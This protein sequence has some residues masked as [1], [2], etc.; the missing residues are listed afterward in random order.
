MTYCINCSTWYSPKGFI[1]IER[2]KYKTD[3]DSHC[4]ECFFAYTTSL[5][6]FYTNHYYKDWIIAAEKAYLKRSGRLYN[7]ECLLE[8]QKIPQG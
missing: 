2:K 8:S 3:S 1:E 5:I 7:N 6:P 4:S